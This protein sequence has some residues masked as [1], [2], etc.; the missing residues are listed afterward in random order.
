MSLLQVIY[1]W[2]L[3][4]SNGH[5]AVPGLATAAADELTARAAAAAI[6]VWG[7]AWRHAASVTIHLDSEA[8]ASRRL[9]ELAADCQT[10]Y[11]VRVAVARA[12][13]GSAAGDGGAALCGQ[14]MAGAGVGQAEAGWHNTHLRVVG[15]TVHQLVDHSPRL[16]AHYF[17]L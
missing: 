14:L 1:W 10:K 6:R 2:R 12:G 17:D 4:L 13:A 8:A 15:D 7:E 5:S 3:E 11:G 16:Q 9:Q